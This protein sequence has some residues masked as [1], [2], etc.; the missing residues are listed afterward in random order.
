MKRVSLRAL[1]ALALSAYI[2]ASS[3]AVAVAQERKARSVLQ[4]TS[5]DAVVVE[6]IAVKDREGPRNKPLMIVIRADHPSQ[7]QA[8]FDKSV[9]KVESFKLT[10]RFYDVVIMRD[11]EAR[12][13]EMLDGMQWQAPSVILFDSTRTK[14]T[15]APG[16]ASFRKV[17][18]SMCTMARLDYATPVESTLQKARI[19]L[20]RFDQV[21]AA[22]SALGIKE[23][24]AGALRAKGDHGKAR[25]LEKDIDKDRRKIDELYSDTDEL[26][27]RLWDGIKMRS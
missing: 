21:D 16:R 24:R 27:S 15:L 25:T 17:W 12:Q 10:A 9:L 5:L 14:R 13:L 3:A 4:T 8:R 6:K 22:K 7:D 11:S 2:I 23:G 1:S 26:W 19:L 20:A 18:G